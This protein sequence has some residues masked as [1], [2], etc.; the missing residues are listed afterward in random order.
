M[1]T[2]KKIVFLF[3]FIYVI[4]YSNSMQFILSD[5][6]HVLWE[7]V[8]PAFARMISSKAEVAS[9]VSG[10]GD[11]LFDYYLVLL[12]LFISIITSLIITAIDYSRPNYKYLTKWFLL[13]L[14]YYIASQMITY[15]FAKLFALQFGE[16]SLFNLE[17][18]L[19]DK[20][21][22]GLLWTFMGHSK[23]YVMFTGIAELLGGLCLLSRKTTLLGALITFGVM[24]NVMM[25]NYCYDVPVKLLSTHLVIFSLFI[26]CYYTKNI[27][28]FL[29]L[30]RDVKAS[31]IPDII[32]LKAQ[33]YKFYIKWTILVLYLSY[34]GYSYNNYRKQ[35]DSAVPSL[36]TGVFEVHQFELFREGRLLKR[37]AEQIVWDKIIVSKRGY[38]RINLKKSTPYNFSTSI[39]EINKTVKFMQSDSIGSDFKFN[40]NKDGILYLN[41]Y[42]K[43]DSLSIILFKKDEYNLSSQTF[44]WVQEYPDN[45]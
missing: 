6:V 19:G 13:I 33:K 43:E 30:N 34:L 28:Q 29:I 11:T 44:R 22:M 3:L 18:S 23:A 35:M 2:L 32:P 16:P 17:Q 37:P 20:S 12:L 5:F 25:M 1:A 7:Y 42:F 9:V 24:I 15:G 45:R 4:V 27:F 21:P 38:A 10:S 39:D 31:I 40:L 14:R 26:L 41:G 8:V 36:L